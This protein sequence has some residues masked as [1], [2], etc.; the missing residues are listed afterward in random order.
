MEHTP[1]K[2]IVQQSPSPFGC[3]PDVSPLPDEQ[4]STLIDHSGDPCPGL[5]DVGRC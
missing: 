5:V 3:N 4:G 1:R 2:A